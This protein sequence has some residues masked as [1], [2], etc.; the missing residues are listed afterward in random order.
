M[1]RPPREDVERL[2]ISERIA[3]PEIARR[4]GVSARAVNNWLIR[5]GIP[6]RSNSEAQRVYRGTE[7]LDAETLECLYDSGLTQAEIG[8]RFGITQSAIKT[9][10]QLFGI[11]ARRKANCGQRNGM[12]GRTHTPEA[13][14]KIAAA[15]A[16]Q[17]SDPAARER[18]AVLTCEQ[19]REGRTG[20]AYNR[21]EQ[22]VAAILDQRE[23]AYELQ[24]R[25]GRFLFDFY[26]PERNMLIEAHGRFWHADPRFYDHAKLTAIQARNVANDARKAERAARDGYA[27]TILWEDDVYAGAVTI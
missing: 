21:L 22:A 12:F 14:A 8:Q 23:I 27:L 4:Y 7:P 24:F 20:K 15:N 6:K 26:L 18:H 17:F 9:K 2:Y 13:R 10:M 19:I 16:R 25:I 11:P 5:Y 1:K 3:T